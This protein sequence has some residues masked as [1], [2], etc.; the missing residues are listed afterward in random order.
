MEKI[1]LLH[2]GKRDP[3]YT[4][5]KSYV[6]KELL[7][8]NAPKGMVK[9][10][11]VRTSTT[12]KGTRKFICGYLGSIWEV[13]LESG[14]FIAP[15]LTGDELPIVAQ[16]YFEWRLGSGG[17]NYVT[18]LVWSG[19]KNL[20]HGEI[21]WCYVYH[22]ENQEVVKYYQDGFFYP[23]GFSWFPEGAEKSTRKKKNS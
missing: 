20:T 15:V 5:L 18:K 19:Q 4:K 16:I 22:G 21:A 12:P 23:N 1:K 6:S 7:K 13:W 8:G 10:L 11:E 2:L 14:E 3:D 9:L 17:G